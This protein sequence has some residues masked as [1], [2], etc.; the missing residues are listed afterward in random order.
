[1]CSARHH[2]LRDRDR[3]PRRAHGAPSPERARCPTIRSRPPRS[4]ARG[5]PARWR[6]SSPTFPPGPASVDRRRAA[7]RWPARSR[8]CAA[9]SSR[10][11]SSPRCSRATEVEDLGV[12]GR[13]PGS[14]RRGVRRRAAARLHRLRRASKRSTLPGTCADDLVRRSVLLYTGESRLSGEHG[15]R[16]P[17][18]VS[19]GRRAHRRG[20]RAHQG[21]R[22]RDGDRAACRRC[23]RARASRRRALGAPAGAASDASPRRRSMRSSNAPSGPARSA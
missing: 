2:A 21:A 10:R 6:T 5:S 15:G 3:R 22:G 9:S 8:C 12:V 17:R 14:L 1:M 20:A 4:A 13:L 23:R 7:S 11:T 18:R 16:G 19:R